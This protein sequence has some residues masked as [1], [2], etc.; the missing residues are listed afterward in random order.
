M[1]T[2]G[3]LRLAAD[4]GVLDSAFVLMYGDSYLPIGIAPV[5]STFE[6]LAPPVLMTVFR[7]AEQCRGPRWTGRPLRQG[8]R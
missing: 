2:A 7:N 3:A 8:G 5:V 6:R 1:G 4:R